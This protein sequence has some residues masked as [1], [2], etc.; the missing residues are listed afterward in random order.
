MKKTLSSFQAYA[1]PF[2]EHKIQGNSMSFLK[3]IFNKEDFFSKKNVFYNNTSETLLSSG[4]VYGGVEVM[5]HSSNTLLTIGCSSVIVLGSL[6]ILECFLTAAGDKLIEQQHEEVAYWKEQADQAIEDRQVK[7]YM[8]TLL[9]KYRIPAEK[10]EEALYKTQY[11]LDTYR[12]YKDD[13]NWDMD[14]FIFNTKMDILG[15][16]VQ[17][18]IDTDSQKLFDE[19]EDYLKNIPPRH[20]GTGQPDTDGPSPLS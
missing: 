4:I 8:K 12:E 3:A 13:P 15:I 5:Q 16:N 20:P 17:K 7:E 18:K 6:K 10:H 1:I 9:E 2:P 19:L 14:T 11:L